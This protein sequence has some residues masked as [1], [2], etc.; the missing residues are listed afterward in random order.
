[1]SADFSGLKTQLQERNLNEA[2]RLA[3]E[4]HHSDAAEM[5]DLSGS[6][7][8]HLRKQTEN[9]AYAFY[10][11]A[12]TNQSDLKESRA[13]MDLKKAL[14]FPG[15]PSRLTRLIQ[16]RV[17]VIQN[18]KTKE[19]KNFDLAI[20]K[21]FGN[22]SSEV[23]LRNEFL[24][25]FGLKQAVRNPTVGG[26]DEVSA[27]GVYRWVGDSNHGEQWSR[28]IRKFKQGNAE[29]SAFFG[30]IL[31]EHIQVTPTCR[32]W[33]RD[34]D[35]I[36]P[37]P[38]AADRLA[39]RGFDILA[40]TGDHLSPRLGIPLSTGFLERAGSSVQ[41]RYVGRAEL[42]RQ[43]T[44]VEQKADDVRGRTILLFDDV[45]NR[46]HTAGACAQRLR[47]AGCE[48]VVLVVLALAESSL[49]SSRRAQ[50]KES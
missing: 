40:K 8:E 33:I 42:T 14:R 4:G 38:V 46:G 32:M 48:R 6:R 13:V 36:V 25:R 12:L 28:L 49:Q 47:E 31:A 30:R 19:V 16:Q 20:A 29:L 10:R 27:I 45:M 2:L 41:S 35:Y 39:Q 23:E 43:Y 37:V 26:I 1:M 22:P 34:V 24:K 50:E 3:R 18:D 44:L 5:F 17:T 9:L 15:V 21:R 7:P 11:R